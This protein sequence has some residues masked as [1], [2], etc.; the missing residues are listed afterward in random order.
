MSFKT[1]YLLFGTL[2]ALLVI[3]GLALWKSPETENLSS[4][5]LRNLH[6]AAHPIKTDDVDQVVIERKNPKEETLTFVK[7]PE[8]KHWQIT[9]PRQLRADSFAVNDLI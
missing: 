7:D 3:F 5:V 9:T 4:Y 2:I 1:T 6:D 8:T